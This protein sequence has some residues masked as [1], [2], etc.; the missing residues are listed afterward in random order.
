MLYTAQYLAVKSCSISKA[1]YVLYCIQGRSDEGE[2]AIPH[3]SV[4]SSQIYSLFDNIFNCMG[5]KL[6]IQLVTRPDKIS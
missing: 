1:Y 5:K 6:N 3:H 4:C 2:V